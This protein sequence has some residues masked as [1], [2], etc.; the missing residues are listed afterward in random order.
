[1]INLQQGCGLR[2]GELVASEEFPH[3]CLTDPRRDTGFLPTKAIEHFFRQLDYKA[4]IRHGM[5]LL[6]MCRVVF[7]R[8]SSG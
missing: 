1:M 6:C 2:F 7:V 3:V 4:F 5:A 8:M